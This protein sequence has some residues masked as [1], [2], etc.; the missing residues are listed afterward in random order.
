MDFFLSGI[1]REAEGWMTSPASVTSAS[2]AAVPAAAPAAEEATF[3]ENFSISR[4]IL[5]SSAI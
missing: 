2:E 5:S 3:C 4:I 1:R